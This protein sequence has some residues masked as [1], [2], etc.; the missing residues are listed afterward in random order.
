[1]FWVLIPVGPT[2]DDVK[3]AQDLIESIVTYEP[4]VSG[5]VFL[6]D[7]VKDRCLAGRFVVPSTCN[8]ISL[9][10][11]RN[12]GTNEFRKTGGL[13]AGIL[14]GLRWI[15]ESTEACFVVKLDSDALVIDPFLDKALLSMRSL[16]DAGM[17]GSIGRSANK[18][19]PHFRYC[20]DA[21]ALLEF[22]LA[23]VPEPNSD[24]EANQGV[25]IA[26][27]GGNVFI[28]H[29]QLCS[30]S[31]LRKHIASALDNGYPL[32]NYCQGG[33]YILTRQMLERMESRGYFEDL[34]LWQQVPIGEDVAMSMYVYAVGLRLHGQSGDGGMFGIQ[35]R[36]LPFGMNDLVVRKYSFIHS[37]KNEASISE[38]DIRA[39]FRERRRVRGPSG[40]MPMAYPYSG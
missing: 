30:F 14:S 26:T 16:T 20:D 12:A 15:Q 33:A 18:D 34:T 9:M 29:D 38:A 40:A 13:C 8:T 23:H 17:L 10:P 3:G 7:G 6:D 24:S 1:M 32:G 22:L 39:F 28:S 2:D 27:P 37:V 5:I 21:R 35:W 31:V 36:G 25:E 4:T 19:S 11:S